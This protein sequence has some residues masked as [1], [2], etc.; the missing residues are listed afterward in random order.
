[1]W[2][3]LGCSSASA[4]VEARLQAHWA[5]QVIAAAGDG[6]LAKREDDSHTAMT[7]DP[8]LGALLGE[9]APSGLAVGVAIET[10]SLVAVR[11]GKSIAALPLV[12]RTLA[13]ALAW[14]DGQHASA[15]GTPT[16]GIAVRTYDMPEAPVRAGAA[17]TADRGALGELAA[18]YAIGVEALRDVV[19]GPGAV[20][21]RV[22]PHHFDLGTI[23]F[24]DRAGDHARQIG[25]GLSPGDGSYAEP[26]FYITPY[27]IAEAAHWAPLAGG[28]VW[29]RE[30]WTGAVLTA[31]V[32]VAAKD[33][34]AR[35][36]LVGEFVDSAIAG[37][38]AVISA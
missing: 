23:M 14:A 7:W 8:A 15:A 32:I 24:L 19:S 11:D 12:D 26:Y 22:W 21:L 35:R 9:P 17:F 20:P 30:G 36:T 33:A 4:L 1:M 10:L 16:R 27:P 13:D 28:G 31:S 37:A 34:D 3:L 18:W 6:W 38:R 5:V 29:H 2:D 25:A